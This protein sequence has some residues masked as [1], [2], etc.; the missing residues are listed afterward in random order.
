M[1]IHQ[2]KRKNKKEEKQNESFP[3][4]YRLDNQRQ[5]QIDLDQ[6]KQTLNVFRVSVC[7]STSAFN[8]DRNLVWIFFFSFLI[9]LMI[10]DETRVYINKE[11][12][13]GMMIF[14]E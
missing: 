2:K 8:K 14:G 6:R 11:V 12:L 4:T 3:L 5:S 1:I 9:F 13:A 10:G 7:G